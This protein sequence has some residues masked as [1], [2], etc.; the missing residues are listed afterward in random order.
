MVVSRGIDPK[1]ASLITVLLSDKL[2]CLLFQYA[3][4][5]S[6]LHLAALEQQKANE[7]LMNLA[8]DQKVCYLF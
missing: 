3:I 7:N 6:A 4:R 2:Y 1:V 8:E 5:N